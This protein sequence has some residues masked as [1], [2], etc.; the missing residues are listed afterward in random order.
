MPQLPPGLA[1]L[2]FR[3]RYRGRIIRVDVRH[4]EAKYSL[5]SG[6][7]LPLGH[8]GKQVT[9]GPDEVKLP[10]PAPPTLPSPTQPAGRVPATRHGRSD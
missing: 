10:I 6:D 5:I 1:G 8:H 7:P 3:M 4:G 9:V 2:C